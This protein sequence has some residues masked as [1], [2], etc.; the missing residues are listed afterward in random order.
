M[1]IE[2]PPSAPANTAQKMLARFGNG[3]CCVIATGSITPNA[4]TCEKAVSTNVFAR[5]APYPP[6]K[7]D[8]PHRKTA[9][10]EQTTGASCAPEDTPVE[11]NTRARSSRA[12]DGKQDRGQFSTMRRRES[13]QSLSSRA[14]CVG[15]R[16]APTHAVEGPC[17]FRCFGT[18]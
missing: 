7:S 15:E 1:A 6:A 17:V 12:A 2:N 3:P 14:E 18:A 8:T 16:S 13:T 11:G 4:H 10:T 9:A 5:R